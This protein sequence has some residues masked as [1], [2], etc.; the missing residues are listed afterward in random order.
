MKAAT[1]GD[2]TSQFV[3]CLAG[4]TAHGEPGGPDGGPD[5]AVERAGEL[6]Q[7]WQHLERTYRALS[8]DVSRGLMAELLTMRV[9]GP[10]RQRITS[11]PHDYEQKRDAF[12]LLRL[13]EPAIPHRSG[14]LRLE[15]FD[16]TAIGHD[17][18]VLCHELVAFNTFVLRQ[19]RCQSD[20][21]LIDAQRGD[22][23]LDAGACW[24]D[25]ALYFAEQVGDEGRVVAIE[26][27]ARNCEVLRK[28]LARNPWAA[29]RVA[30]I[31]LPLWDRPGEV[32]RYRDCG[33]STKVG[34]FAGPEGAVSTAID[35]I[36]ACEALERVDLIKMDVEG[37]EL[38][39]LHGGLRTLRDH[40]PDLAISAYHDIDG[41]TTIPA[42]L[43]E[44]GY[45]LY[46]RHFTRHDEETVLFA[47]HPARRDRC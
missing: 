43:T 12:R 26:F 33:A 19:Y 36:V 38:A 24:G 9:V 1:H 17:L 40:T 46:L 23:V 4:S 28:N 31:E 34:R 37:A 35:E 13:D 29:R 47:R 20:G 45:Q 32:L 44:L 42:L 10:R 27:V 5:G 18:R 25:T 41:L 16:L 8:D 21:L 15:W 22:V 39:A 7:H 30:L 14:R 6:S 2:L 11:I 3:A